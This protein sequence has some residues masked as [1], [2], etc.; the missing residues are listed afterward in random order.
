MIPSALRWI[1]AGVVVAMGLA[2]G[3]WSISF[4]WSIGGVSRAATSGAASLLSLA[5]GGSLLAA[6]VIGRWKRPPLPG[7]ALLI[8]GGTAWFIGEW[9]TPGAPSA[10]VFAIGLLAGAAWPAVVAHAAVLLGRT[11]PDWL[12]RALLAAGYAICLGGLGVIPT[13]SY[14]PSSAGCTECPNNVL[15]LFGSLEVAVTATRVGFVLQAVWVVLLS[16]VLALRLRERPG[17]A[18]QLTVAVQLP[19]VVALGAVAVEGIHGIA[20]G[21]LSNDELDVALWAVSAGGLI[22]CA[23]GAM[24]QIVRA[25]T[26]R[27]SVVRIALDVASAP[28]LGE[29]QRTLAMILDDPALA[30]SYPI[31]GHRSLDETGRD[32]TATP[33][34][35]AAGRGVTTV[36]RDGVEVARIDHR[37][38]IQGEGGRLEDTVAAAR[39]WLESERLHAIQLARMVELRQSRAD[40][41]AAAD[42]ERWRLERDLH[43]GSQQRLVGLAFE[44]GLARETASKAADSATEAH[45]ALAETRVRGALQEL[46]HLAHGIYPPALSDQGLGA[47]LE[48]LA[49]ASD[50]P[51]RLAASTMRRFDQRLE[52]TA[53]NVA[54]AVLRAGVMARATIK[55]HGSDDHLV[56]EIDGSGPGPPADL[57]SDLED[58][59]LALDGTL[60]MGGDDDDRW[61]RLELPC[62]S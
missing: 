27:R 56:L 26:A 49:D 40:V 1:S 17:S 36:T 24:L 22:G 20:R 41:V 53:Y 35:P 15:A 57:R 28:R 10:I 23:I 50:I 11:R 33:G 16:I 51:V 46:R 44:L 55:F 18:R 42:A 48:D 59:V 52:A 3:A 34:P 2:I 32:T 29:L 54:A 43:D 5:A 7:A 45:L 12:V 62:V 14:V 38:D 47:A 6:G 37:V 31:D 39:L 4:A 13:I 19:V 60:K 30:I 9:S 8:L 61:I 25:R 21:S 58:R